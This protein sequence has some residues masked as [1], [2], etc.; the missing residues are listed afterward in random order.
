MAE[1]SQAMEDRSAPAGAGSG[2]ERRHD[3]PPALSVDESIMHSVKA[4]FEIKTP[5]MEAE[6][7]AAIK[8]ALAKEGS[9]PVDDTFI[10]T[11]YSLFTI[12]HDPRY[13]SSKL[14]YV[15]Y[16]QDLSTIIRSLRS[17]SPDQREAFIK[18]VSDSLGIITKKKKQV[19]CR[20]AR[21]RPR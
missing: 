10:G 4:N 16:P 14:L 5:L 8:E 15:L 21:N 6:L 20:N 19:P 11:L 18:T 7:V 12:N 2:A 9:Y 3:D 17:I 13:S 1:G